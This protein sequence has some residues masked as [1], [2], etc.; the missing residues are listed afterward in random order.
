MKSETNQIIFNI[1]LFIII[2]ILFVTIVILVK[3][4]NIIKSDSIIYGMK[5]HN[6][7]S[8]SCID[9][10]GLTWTS[11]ENGFIQGD[12]NYLKIT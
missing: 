1:L 8:C 6:F 5:I 11:S 10:K 3:N 7:T 2:I 9:D 4:I 12:K